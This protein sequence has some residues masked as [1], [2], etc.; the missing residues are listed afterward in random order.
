MRNDSS[1]GQLDLLGL[2]KGDM[3]KAKADEW[4][5]K[6]PDAWAFMRNRAVEYTYQHRK[7]GIGDLCEEVRWHKR[8]EGVDS[9]KV[10]NNYRAPLARRLKEEYP[11]CAQYIETRESCVDVA[12]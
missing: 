3:Y 11:P 4:V 9:F 1:D 5:K 7:F 12:K 10:N 8:A 6:N 2:S